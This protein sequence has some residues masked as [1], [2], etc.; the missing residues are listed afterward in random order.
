MVTEQAQTAGGWPWQFF[1]IAGSI[2]LALRTDGR[3]THINQ[4]G[5][6]TLGRSVQEILERDWTECFVPEQARDMVG[7]ILRQ[8]AAGAANAPERFEHPVLCGDG[9]QRIIAWRNGTV[10]NASGAIAA[11]LCS[12][13]DVTERRAAEAALRESEARFRATFEQTAV[14]LA[15]VGL[16]GRFLRLNDK[17]CEITGYGRAELQTRTFGDITHPADLEADLA[18]ARALR[19]GKIAHYTMEKR[20]IRKDGSEVWVNLTGSL[21]SDAEGRPAYFIAVVEDISLRK[22]AEMLQVDG[23]LQ[24]LALTAA[25]AGAWRWSAS[26]GRLLWAP[27]TYRILGF[28]PSEAPPDFSTWLSRGVH[29]DDH[30]LLHDVLNRAGATGVTEF[31]L[32]I[33]CLH[34]EAGLRWI[35]SVG[36]VICDDAHRLISAYGIILDVTDR[37]RIADQLHASEERLQMAM[38]V[39]D[40]GVWD[41]DIVTGA[42]TWSENF[43]KLVGIE[44]EA[45]PDSFEGWRSFVH[46]EDRADVGQALARALAADGD[47][48]AE[49]RMIRPDGTVRWTSTRGA[50]LR[51]EA[52]QPI[53]M[54]GIDM[55]VT[56]RKLAEERQ[57]LV[58]RELDHRI[59]NIITL[60]KSLA[61][62]TLPETPARADFLDRMIALG[63]AHALLLANRDRQVEMLEIAE[64]ALSSYGARVRTSGESLTLAPDNAQTVALILHE[65]ATNAVKH[66]A[67]AQNEGTVSV[68]WQRG[69]GPQPSVYLL[70]SEAAKVSV[71]RPS[72]EGFGLHL[73]QNVVAA[74][75]GQI[76]LSFHAHGLRARLTLPICDPEVPF[77][78]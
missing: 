69:D 26:D 41:W 14:G 53:R 70:W 78:G 23:A 9:S 49:Y 75:G 58:A 65:L 5:A 33:R 7:A 54:I 73:L 30:H 28:E 27:E 32:E 25:N 50:V 34:P 76:D 10:R 66:G 63:N 24:R 74:A 20:Y 59:R 48:A 47:Y 38:A 37:R 6:E 46:P 31:N 16:D 19:E 43:C 62:Q 61:R 52:G 39:G 68:E 2:L 4:A 67:L 35:A 71:E 13:E 17:L 57:S 29:P 18:Q 72:R 45:F 64:S 55:D 8:V 11:I 40:I 42:V 1:E 21:V 56:A 51:D 60:V 44:P 36:R 12:G 3:V 15:H 77:P 22:R